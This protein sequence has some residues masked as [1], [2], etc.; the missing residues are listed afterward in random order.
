MLDNSKNANPSWV[1]EAP[2]AITVCD[3][4]GIILSMND[5]SQEAFA[6]Y[7]GGDLIGTNLLDCHPE[8]SK[9]KLQDLLTNPRANIYTIE[10]H[11]KKKMIYQTPWFQDGTFAGLV[12]LAL[13]LPESIPHFVRQG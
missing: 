13:D 4:Q 6:D 8:P 1:K 9:S 12:E 11:G 3:A 5:R 10:K 2:Y 7:G